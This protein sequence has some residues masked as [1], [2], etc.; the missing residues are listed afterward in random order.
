MPKW[1]EPFPLPGRRRA[2]KAAIQAVAR[3]HTG[4]RRAPGPGPATGFLLSCIAGGIMKQQARIVRRTEL[5]GAP[6][7]SNVAGPKTRVLRS[8]VQHRKGAVR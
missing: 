5:A 6:T 8:S 7:Q 2:A 1:C 4:G 3:V